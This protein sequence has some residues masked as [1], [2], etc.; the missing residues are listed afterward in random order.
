MN[1]ALI[2]SLK[3]SKACISFFPIPN[4]NLFLLLIKSILPCIFLSMSLYS[5]SSSILS[6]TSFG[7]LLLLCIKACMVDSIVFNFFLISFCSSGIS[8]LLNPSLLNVIC[9]DSK[10]FCNSVFNSSISPLSNL[11]IDLS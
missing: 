11:S 4:L 6:L 7:I 2:D 9:P 3:L 5:L 10:A 1:S 8:N